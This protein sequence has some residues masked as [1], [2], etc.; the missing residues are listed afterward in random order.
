MPT[1]EAACQRMFGENKRGPR[2]ARI[3]KVSAL[4]TRDSTILV[5]ER[6]V[7]KEVPKSLLLPWYEG[8]LLLDEMCTSQGKG[9][10]ISAEWIDADLQKVLET[11]RDKRQLSSALYVERKLLNIA[12]TG[13]TVSDSEGRKWVHRREQVKANENLRLVAGKGVDS[14]LF[15]V[16]EVTGYMPPWEAFCHEKCGLYQDFYQVVWGDPCSQTDYSAVENGCSGI[17]GA[18]WEPDECLPVGLDSLR[19]AAKRKWIKLRREQEEVQKVQRQ[20]AL[21]NK[22]PMASPSPESELDASSSKRQKPQRTATMKRDGTPLNRDLFMLSHGHDLPTVDPQRFSDIRSGWPK[23]I[24]EYPS[25]YGPANPPGMCLPSCDCMDDQRIQSA[26]E[27]HKDWLEDAARSA[28]ASRVIENFTARKDFVVRHGQYAKMG[29]NQLHYFSTVTERTHR[30][31]HARAALDIAELV[32]SSV[33]NV[34]RE[35]PISAFSSSSTEPI[36]VPPCAFLNTGLDSEPLEIV[37]TTVA[38][39]PLPDWIES[40][41]E[42]GELR[43]SNPKAAQALQLRVEFRHNE[44]AVASGKVSLVQA[45]ADAAP[46]RK[47]TST[48]ASRFIEVSKTGEFEK[49]VRAILWEH[50]QDIY[51]A[52]A[53]SGIDRSLGHWLITMARLLRMLRSTTIATLTAPETVGA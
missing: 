24:E 29:G 19:I 21:L 14:G 50:F 45:A 38:G 23:T 13:A 42:N 30:P 52:S 10:R 22:R 48:I 41:A 26:W 40:N 4:E 39:E 3:S 6:G 28:A 9:E 31:L 49:P 33:Q 12:V 1:E 35:I 53:K 18:T 43:I 46:W 16:R 15:G 27:T 7:T 44:G 37:F 36:A 5:A 11:E 32:S 34:L 8:L 17:K 47:A 20:K 25:G 51:D 2:A